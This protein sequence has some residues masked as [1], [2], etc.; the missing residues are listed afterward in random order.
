MLV[1]CKALVLLLHTSLGFLHRLLMVVPS[2][3]QPFMRQLSHLGA[4][5]KWRF[6]AQVHSTFGLVVI[7]HDLLISCFILPEFHRPGVFMRPLVVTLHSTGK[8]V[9]CQQA[10]AV[11][12]WGLVRQY[13][14]QRGCT[15]QLS[16]QLLWLS[17]RHHLPQ[18]L[19]WREMLGGQALQTCLPP[20]LQSL[21]QAQQVCCSMKMVGIAF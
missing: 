1:W 2:M 21:L 11:P 3:L 20:R 18:L 12:L 14:T 16:W 9:S 6:T 7:L 5:H 10:E 8:S 19:A 17:R 13:K 4:F 15:K